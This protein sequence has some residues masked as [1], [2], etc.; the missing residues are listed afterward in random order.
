VTV[1]TPTVTGRDALLA[2]A[3]ASVAAQTLD[4]PPVHLVAVDHLHRGPGAVRNRLVRRATTEFV[5]FLDDDDLLDADHLATLVARARESGADVVASW[6]R[7]GDPPGP[8]PAPHLERFDADRLRSDNYIPVTVVAR[9]AAVLAAGGFD[10]H[11]RYEDWA[12]WLRML[13]RGCRF[14]IVPRE[15]WTYRLRPSGRTDAPRHTWR[16]RARHVRRRLGR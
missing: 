15:T 10:R 3:R 7:W 13:D 1:I 16:Q 4:P 14:E 8:F 12:L 11:D 9:R 6:W 2:G 5:A